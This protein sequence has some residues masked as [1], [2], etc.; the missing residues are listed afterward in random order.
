[1]PKSSFAVFPFLAAS[2]PVRVGKLV[3]R[4]TTDTGNLP[5]EDA[6][7]VRVI[8]DM[9]YLR[10]DE[11]SE[12][13]SYAA[14]PYVDIAD[15]KAD[16]GQ[17]RAVQDLVA[18]ACSEPYRTGGDPFVKIEHANLVLFSPGLVVTSLVTPKNRS[19]I[20][21]GE[22]P[23]PH[24]LPLQVEGY[25]GLY[26]LRLPIWVTRGSRLYGTIPHQTTGGFLDLAHVMGIG[27]RQE[28][29]QLSKAIGGSPT[30]TSRRVM[31][32]IRWCNEA[33][34][35]HNGDE[36]SVVFLAIALETLLMLSETE[37]KSQALSASIKLLLGPLRRLDSW[38]NQF[39]S[40]RSAIIHEGDAISLDFIATDDWKPKSNGPR[41]QSLLSYG[42]RVFRLCARTLLAGADFVERAGLI[43]SL[44][45][46][47]ERFETIIRM[48]DDSSDNPSTR[49]SRI[50]PIV[51]MTSTFQFEREPDLKID[52]LLGAARRLAATLSEL[53]SGLMHPF[54][55]MLD[56]M[57]NAKKSGD[58]FTELSALEALYSRL[59]E[60]RELLFAH[61]SASDALKLFQVIWMYTFTHY[62]W[63]EKEHRSD[64][65]TT[66]S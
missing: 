63:I 6:D 49:L 50:G 53:E 11:K 48:L 62:Y 52:T 10:D 26:G 31:K 32:A 27:R 2:A 4:S 59:E 5:E 3:F 43:D 66:S 7:H 61:E 13:S 55:A 47:Q 17:L 36:A 22:P 39:Y 45:T 8:A 42:R 41:Y 16:L 64:S 44:V 15:P 58:H 9:L 30:E 23:S 54:S 40:A 19:H 35:S 65:Q 24:D 33:S 18:Y 28:L 46:N 57:A 60:L 12:Q 1:M 29:D 37:K 56:A 34:S 21:G 51:A 38:T 25:A 20:V 14:V